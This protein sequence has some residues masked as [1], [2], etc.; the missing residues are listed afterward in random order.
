MVYGI[1]KVTQLPLFRFIIIMVSIIM[2]NND[3]WDNYCIWYSKSH[4]TPT[5]Q[6][7]LFFWSALQCQIMIIWIIMVYGIVKVTQLPLF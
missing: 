3:N 1:V 7:L 2:S 6:I 4:T 5:I